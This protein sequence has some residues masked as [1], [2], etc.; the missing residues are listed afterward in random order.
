M[1]KTRRRIK[2]KSEIN[3]IEIKITKI[4]EIVIEII[5]KIIL[6]T[7][8]IVIVKIDLIVIKIE[9]IFAKNV[10]IVKTRSIFQL[11]KLIILLIR[12]FKKYIINVKR[13]TSTIFVTILNIEF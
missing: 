3:K 5:T 1:T 7:H 6:K 2:I 4:K 9:K 8:E 12:K 11:S 10:K 13:K